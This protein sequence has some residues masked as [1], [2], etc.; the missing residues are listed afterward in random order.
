MSLLD[1]YEHTCPQ[2]GSTY[3]ITSEDVSTKEVGSINC[4]VCGDELVSWNDT[5]TYKA[6][7][8]DRGEWPPPK[9]E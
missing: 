4:Y 3:S 9:T 1:T 6:A 8:R 7:L 5:R 2:C